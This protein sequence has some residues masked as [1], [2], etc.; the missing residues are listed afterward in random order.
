[1]GNGRFT[2]VAYKTVKFSKN[3]NRSM[4]VL[5]QALDLFFNFQLLFAALFQIKLLILIFYKILKKFVRKHE[6]I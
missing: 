4:P 5:Y 2:G 1:M 6:L 3:L